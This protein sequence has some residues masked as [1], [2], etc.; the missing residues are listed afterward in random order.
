MA[1]S[2]DATAKYLSTVTYLTFSFV[3]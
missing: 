2:F 3:N 1:V